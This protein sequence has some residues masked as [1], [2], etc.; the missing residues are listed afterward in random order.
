MAMYLQAMWEAEHSDI[1]V[2][3][4]LDRYAIAEE[5]F[6][7]ESGPP[8]AYDPDEFGEGNIYY[9]PALMWHELRERIGDPEFF[10]LVREWPAARDNRSAGRDDYW[11][12]L[13]E[14][15]GEELTAFFDAW[16]LGATTPPR[17]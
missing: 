5:G 11:A 15:T 10:R 4:Q 13:E 12:W 14:E 1:S 16:L 17:D 2:E 9:G 7:A 3:E 6:R 8:A